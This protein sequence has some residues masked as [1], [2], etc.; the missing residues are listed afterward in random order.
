MRVIYR[1]IRYSVHFIPYA[2]CLLG[3]ALYIRC[4][5]SIEKY[6]IQSTSYLMQSVYWFMYPRV[7]W[8]RPHAGKKSDAF[9][10]GRPIFAGNWGCNRIPNQFPSSQ[11]STAMRIFLTHFTYIS[12]R[13][14][15]MMGVP[16]TL[17]WV[18]QRHHEPP[19]LLPPPNP[20]TRTAL[21]LPT[22]VHLY[23]PDP[24]R[25]DT[26]YIRTG[27]TS[28][29]VSVSNVWPTVKVWINRRIEHNCCLIHSN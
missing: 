14:V 8:V 10:S 3:C 9:R 28:P 17:R 29:R 6:G 26:A 27:N 5:L 16:W 22:T 20:V 12:V 24:A 25:Q 21:F 13:L 1:K 11:S 18:L 19:N 15:T 7:I 4:A 23:V 2:V